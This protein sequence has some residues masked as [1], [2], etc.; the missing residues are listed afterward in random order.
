MAARNATPFAPSGRRGQRW[1]LRL[2][3]LIGRRLPAIIARG[4]GA[5]LLWQRMRAEVAS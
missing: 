1:L 2:G 4:T 5:N 3:W